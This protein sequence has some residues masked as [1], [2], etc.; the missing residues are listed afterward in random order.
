M[1][2]RKQVTDC[3]CANTAFAKEFMET[4]LGLHSISSGYDRIVLFS[5]TLIMFRK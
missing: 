2:I 3:T 5:L 1:V 4:E